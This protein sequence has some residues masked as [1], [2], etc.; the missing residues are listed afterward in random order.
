MRLRKSKSLTRQAQNWAE[1]LLRDGK[2]ELSQN[3]TFGQSIAYKFKKNLDQS[4]P[5]AAEIT[6]QWYSEGEKYDHS[7]GS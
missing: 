5:D 4:L 7:E 6:D 3:S 1:E 2:Y